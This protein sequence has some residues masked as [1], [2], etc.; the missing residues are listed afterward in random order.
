[1]RFKGGSEMKNIGQYVHKLLCWKKEL[2]KDSRAVEIDLRIVLHQPNYIFKDQTQINN[3][4][5][6]GLGKS[7]NGMQKLET[8][9]LN[10]SN[11]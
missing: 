5:L 6:K 9:K 10:F 3:G 11:T 4:G 8:L 1:M 7:L 2:I